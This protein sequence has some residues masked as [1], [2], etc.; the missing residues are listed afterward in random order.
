[1]RGAYHALA[2]ATLDAAKSKAKADGSPPA[3]KRKTAEDEDA[4]PPDADMAALMGFSS[5]Q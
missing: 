3:K 1:M 2:R 5:F 4:P